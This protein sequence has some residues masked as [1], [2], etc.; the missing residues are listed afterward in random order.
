MSL[1]KIGEVEFSA[2][3]EEKVTHNNEVTDRPV[4]DLGYISDHVKE[5]PITFSIEG[6]ILG[7]DAYERLK[8]LRDYCKGKQTY[9][10]YGRNIFSNVVIESLS[11]THSK[12]TRNGCSFKLSCKVIKQAVSKTIKAQNPD[13]ATKQTVAKGKAKQKAKRKVTSQTHKVKNKGKQTKSKKKVDKQK[14]ITS[15]KQ[16]KEIL[17]KNPSSKEMFKRLDKYLFEHKSFQKGGGVR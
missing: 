15:A 6:V 3:T 12:Q 8:Q 1:S 2:I 4:E 7:E 17:A 9:K 11:T 13:P 5:K 10:Y 14:K 16:Y